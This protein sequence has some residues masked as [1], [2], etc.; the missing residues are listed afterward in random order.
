MSH[1]RRCA[2]S[3]VSFTCSMLIDIREQVAQSR[4]THLPTNFCFLYNGHPLDP[5]VEASIRAA[6][7]AI[8]SET[9][10]M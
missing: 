4:L 1:S 9:Q 3:D 2:N 10:L 6:E 5:N 7:V 8:V